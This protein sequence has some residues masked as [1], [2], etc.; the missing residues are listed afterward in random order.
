[1]KDVPS[2]QSNRRSDRS[3]EEDVSTGLEN[4]IGLRKVLTAKPSKSIR[5]EEKAIRLRKT[6]SAPIRQKSKY[7]KKDRQPRTNLNVIAASDGEELL[8]LQGGLVDEDDFLPDKYCSGPMGKLRSSLVRSSKQKSKKDRSGKLPLPSP[9][10]ATHISHR[11]ERDPAPSES[12]RTEIRS[13]VKMCA[14]EPSSRNLDRQATSTEEDI[15]IIVSDPKSPAEHETTT[16]KPRRK[17]SFQGTA[18][19][20]P[21]R[22]LSMPHFLSGE[23][24]RQ[25]KMEAARERRRMLDKKKKEKEGNKSPRNNKTVSFKKPTTPEE[26]RRQL[27]SSKLDVLGLARQLRTRGLPAKPKTE[28]MKTSTQPVAGKSMVMKR[29]VEEE[30]KKEHLFVADFDPSHFHNPESRDEKGSTAKEDL[31]ASRR[32]E[33]SNG[34]SKLQGDT[35]NREIFVADFDAKNFD[36]HEDLEGFPQSEE[37]IQYERSLSPSERLLFKLGKLDPDGCLVDSD[38]SEREPELE[39]DV[40]IELEA[41]VR[42]KEPR[43]SSIVPSDDG[44]LIENNDVELTR[45]AV[46][47]HTDESLVKNTDFGVELS[48]QEI[49]Y[50][51]GELS[52][53][54][55]DHKE[56]D[57]VYNNV[58]TSIKKEIHDRRSQRDHHTTSSKD[59]QPSQQE[60]VRATTE[61]H[62]E[63]GTDKQPSL[64]ADVRATIDHHDETG[65]VPEHLRAISK[66]DGE[67]SMKPPIPQQSTLSDTTADTKES[68][69]RRGTINEE[70]HGIGLTAII[71]VDSDSINEDDHDIGLKPKGSIEDVAANTSNND[72]DDGSSSSV[73]AGNGSSFDDSIATELNAPMAPPCSFFGWFGRRSTTPIN[74][75]HSE[76]ESPSQNTDR[77][78]SALGSMSSRG[79][80]ESEIT[81]E[82]LIVSTMVSYDEEDFLDRLEYGMCGRSSF[83]AD[84]AGEL[85]E[86][87]AA[88]ATTTTTKRSSRRSGKQK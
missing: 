13:L 9:P 48:P 65:N 38:T 77:I 29:L 53:T 15:E 37:E 56:F 70:H 59:K 67:E 80:F 83:P 46:S 2:R 6:M 66:E 82:S 61:H 17:L 8:V 74:G 85:T 81:R 26:S 73:S 50:I 5:D 62:T 51:L 88:A 86:A 43:K 68:P 19:I 45:V 57:N 87:A 47:N 75:S 16:I 14:G 30:D 58:V 7:T 42:Q 28:K 21:K 32:Q 11:E 49:E 40:H 44:R 31:Q 27:T 18:A 3:E 41:D 35:E 12:K 76:L 84:D 64:Q 39:A 25:S 4:K 69:D 36:S 52:L 23:K 55:G 63:S 79:S 34:R 10:T 24:S 60:N 20:K 78:E 71:N 54:S 33:A 22:M 72:D 1:M